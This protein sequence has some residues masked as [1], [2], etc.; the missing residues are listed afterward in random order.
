[1]AL[2]DRLFKKNSIDTEEG[3]Y[4]ELLKKSEVPYGFNEEYANQEE[5][6]LKIYGH[7][8]QLNKHIK[9]LLISDTHGNL[10]EEEFEKFLSNHK[11]YDICL[12]LGDHSGNDIGKI[13]NYVPKDKIYAL[14]G[15]H[16]YNYIKEYDLNNLNGCVININGVKMLGIEGSFKYKPGEYPSFTQKES[17][18]FLNDKEKVDILICHDNRFNSEMKN[19]PAHQGLFGI[20]YYIYKNRIPYYIHGHNHDKYDKELING[21]KEVSTYMYDYFE[22]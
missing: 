9:M 6:L 15:N 7:C 17:I 4:E 16:D 13:L 10:N 18:T 1:M 20:T 22:I 8:D 19:R 11:N 3:Y 21:T 14:L 12:I 2:F 5:R